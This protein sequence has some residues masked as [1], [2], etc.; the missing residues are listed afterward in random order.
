MKISCF[1]RARLL[2][3]DENIRRPARRLR[4]T[5]SARFFSKYGTT[6]CDMAVMLARSSSTQVTGMLKSARHAETTVARYPEP[7]T[8]ICIVIHPF[9]APLPQKLG[10]V[11]SLNIESVFRAPFVLAPVRGLGK[12]LS[13][14][15]S[16]E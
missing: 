2:I 4:R 15:V 12:V 6:P 3:S 16:R 5:T 9:G 10:E 1:W 8:P 13:G 11:P 14:W 7:Y